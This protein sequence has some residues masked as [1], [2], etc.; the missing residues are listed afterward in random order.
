[1]STPK[2]LRHFVCVAVANKDAANQA[3]HTLGIDPEGK[4]NTF[5]IELNAKG[6]DAPATHH[7]AMGRMPPAAQ[8]A[9]LKNM[10]QGTALPAIWFS[11]N[12]D[13]GKELGTCI[14]S[15]DGSHLGEVLTFDSILKII[16]LQRRTVPFLTQ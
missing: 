4:L 6:D 9:I 11:L 2:Y 3:A 14:A 16:G 10:Q 5:Q 7:C 15:Y 12:D 8:A 13:S 1:M